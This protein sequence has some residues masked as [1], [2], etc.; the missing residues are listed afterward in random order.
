MRGAA[1]LL[2]TWAGL[3]GSLQSQSAEAD[4][5]SA[6]DGVMQKPGLGNNSMA[7]L[8]GFS[9][10]QDGVI[11]LEPA[12]HKARA[13]VWLLGIR[14]Q[15]LNNHNLQADAHLKTFLN[16]AMQLI[17]ADIAALLRLMPA[18]ENQVGSAWVLLRSPWTPPAPWDDTVPAS[19]EKAPR[20]KIDSW[21]KGLLK[22]TFG[23]YQLA[24]SIQHIDCQF[25]IAIAS[26]W[27]QRWGGAM[28]VAVC[29]YCHC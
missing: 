29:L 15:V 11:T 1:Q 25:S 18:T 14:Q 2:R 22:R 24:A 9:T 23:S 26:C 4:I 21:T 5:R 12:W 17:R 10:Q 16:E 6:V 27:G 20:A 13:F 3:P 19:R 28:V 8:K 7:D